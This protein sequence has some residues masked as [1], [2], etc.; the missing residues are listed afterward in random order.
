MLRNFMVSLIYSA[1]KFELLKL[2][3]YIF[4]NF[5]FYGINL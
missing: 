4:G 3:L 5:D 2:M 1:F